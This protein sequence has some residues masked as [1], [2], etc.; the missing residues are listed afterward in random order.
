MENNVINGECTPEVMN[1]LGADILFHKVAMKPGSAYLAAAFNDKPIL[2]HSGNPGAA[3]VSLEMLTKPFLYRYSGRND[4]ENKKI[5]A[6]LKEGFPKKSP[7]RR[8]LPGR[9]SVEDGKAVIYTSQRQGNGMLSHLGKAFVYAD[10]PAGTGRI[11]PYD[12]VSAYISI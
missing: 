2:S 4:W 3:Y 11:D 8:F 10:I 9:L 5:K 12:A 1:S 7:Q 6:L